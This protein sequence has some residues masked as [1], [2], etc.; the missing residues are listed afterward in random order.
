MTIKKFLIFVFFIT[1]ALPVNANVAYM[2]LDWWKNYNDEILNEH[3]HNL[4]NNNHD[5][6]IAAYKTK[7]AKENIRLIGAN[8]LPQASFTPEFV[9]TFKGSTHRFGDIEIPQYTQT[10]I[11]LPIEASYEIDIWGQNYLNKKSAKKQKEI[12]DEDERAAY[13]YITS[14]F[15]ANYYNLINIRKCS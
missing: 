1:L 12:A 13:I 15:V 14:S 2:N 6:K 11:L 4:Y 3:L 5:L 10:N 9:Q 7:Q 8:Q